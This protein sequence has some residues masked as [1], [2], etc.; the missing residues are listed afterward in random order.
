MAWDKSYSQSLVY[1]LY[2]SLHG[3]T[4]FACTSSGRRTVGP[5][6]AAPPHRY[7]HP[8]VKGKVVPLHTLEV[9]GQRY[10]PYSFT[11]SALDGV[12]GQYH[13]PVALYPGKGTPVPIVQEGPRARDGIWSRSR[14]SR[15]TSHSPKRS[16]ISRD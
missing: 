7:P 9:Q 14:V 5:F 10:S 6:A 3:R 15:L 12:S 8:T 1:A 16:R 11:A 13:A 2:I 4:L